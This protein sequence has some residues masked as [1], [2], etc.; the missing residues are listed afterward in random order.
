MTDNEIKIDVYFFLHHMRREGEETTIG[1]LLVTNDVVGSRERED[2]ARHLMILSNNSI[3]SC[4]SE[5][6]PW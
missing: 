4:Q 2:Y 5:N 3:S 1:F 6:I